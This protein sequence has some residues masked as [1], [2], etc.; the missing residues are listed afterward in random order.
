MPEN[1]VVRA[2]IDPAIK[3]AASAVL[4]SAGLTV[5]DVFRLLLIRIAHDK[6]LPFDPLIPNDTTID[7]MRA[8][9]AGGLQRFA[10]ITDLMKDLHA[11]D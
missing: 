9:R 1:D 6:A 10:S 7:A 5:S 11:K 2:R 4:A 8:A 3:A